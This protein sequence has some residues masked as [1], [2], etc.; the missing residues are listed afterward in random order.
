M[1]QM[2][3]KRSAIILSVVVAAIIVFTAC[4]GVATI[5]PDKLKIDKAY[6]FA[7]NIT[8]NDFVFA[9]EFERKDADAWEVVLTEPFEVEGIQLTYNGGELTAVVDGLDNS[10]ALPDSNAATHI[11]KA[12]ENAINGEGREV[13]AYGEEIR[14]SSRAG[15]SAFS[16]EL[17][18]NKQTLEPISISIHE[19]GLK[20]D[21]SEVQVSRIAQILFG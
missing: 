21:F 5:N 16:Y 17:T 19:R 12:F 1:K 15:G 8:Y 20:A 3:I 13:V 2:K 18:F 14:I 4:S 11:I 6:K 7:A 9:A 10:R